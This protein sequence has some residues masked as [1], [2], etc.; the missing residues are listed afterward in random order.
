M[1]SFPMFG[2]ERLKL[3]LTMKSMH[4]NRPNQIALWK[5]KYKEYYMS[6]LRI[7]FF[8]DE[9]PSQLWTQLQKQLW[10]DSLENFTLKRIWTHDLCDSGGVLYQLDYQANWKL[11]ILFHIFYCHLL[12]FHGYVTIFLW[13]NMVNSF[14]YY[15]VNMAKKDHFNLGRIAGDRRLFFKRISNMEPVHSFMQR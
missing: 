14:K 12:I 5:V 2:V 11:V 3:I 4:L 8:I 6:E 13:S 9:W 7:K 15:M 10:K 1:S